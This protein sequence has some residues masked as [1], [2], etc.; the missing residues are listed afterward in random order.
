MSP[1]LRRAL[2]ARDPTCR[3]P[4]CKVRFTQGHHVEHWANGGETKLSNLLNLCHHHH[5]C[6]H[7]GGYRVE[8]FPDGRARFYRPDGRLIPEV[9]PQPK[10]PKNPTEAL[11]EKN[12]EHGIFIT[13]QEGAPK[14]G[15]APIDW[16]WAVDAP[17]QNLDLRRKK[18]G[19]TLH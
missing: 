17:L 9:P 3:F 10:A 4:G 1:A 15:Y 16:D 2:D 19:P 8:L 5:H 18:K 12:V 6:V 14:W 11:R 13:G 7:D